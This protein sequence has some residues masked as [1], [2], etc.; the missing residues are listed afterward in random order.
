MRFVGL[1]GVAPIISLI[2]LAMR[3]SGK[4]PLP[5]LQSA[6]RQMGRLI[7]R[8]DRR[9][10]EI[11]LNNLRFAFGG[12]RSSAEL[13]RMAI[14]VFEG[15]GQIP[16]EVCWSLQVDRR[17]WKKFFK[18]SG[19][20]HYRKAAAGGN[21]VLFL[22]AHV[23]NW[24]LFPVVGAMAGIPLHVVYRPLDSPVFD[25]VVGRIRRRF[26]ARLIPKKKSVFKINQALR[27]GQCIAILLDQ[28]VDWYEG[29]FVDF[30]G[31]RACTSKGLA[32]LSILSRAPVVPVF[33]VREGAGFHAHFEPPIYPRVSG[34]R[35][36]D[37]EENTQRY[38]QAI[39]S[40]VRRYPDQWF[41]VHQRWKTPPYHPI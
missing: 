26:G 25:E 24:E 30:M 34:D 33:L 32:T 1:G 37:L 12:Q 14:G 2:L 18:I 39:E 16:L 13:I 27:N 41:W 29:V 3:L 9:H 8:L 10:R 17:N 23:G 5:L 6:G 22:T 7:F 36:R 28:N 19:L 40:V 31:H 20:D 11:A 38:N 4:L 15:I 35:I 21:G